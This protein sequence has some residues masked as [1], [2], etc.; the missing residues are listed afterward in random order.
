MSSTVRGSGGWG[1]I[2]RG[3]CRVYGL[4]PEVSGAKV[5]GSECSVLGETWRV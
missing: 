5:Q 4:G 2:S 3:V 1:L